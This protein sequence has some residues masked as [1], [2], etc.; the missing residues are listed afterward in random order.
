MDKQGL[1]ID[2]GF[3][4]HRKAQTLLQEAGTEVLNNRISQIPLSVPEW[5]KPVHIDHIYTRTLLEFC[6]INGVNTLEQLLFE[7]KG[8]IFCSIV[9][10]KPCEE[11]YDEGQA[12]I[13]AESIDGFNISV[14]FHLSTSK[15][16]GETLRTHLLSGGEFAIVAQLFSSSDEKVVFQPLI[17]GFP[18]IEDKETGASSWASYSDFYR[19]HLEDFDEFSCVSEAE[20]PAEFNE[21]KQIKESAFKAALGRIL[22]ESTPK[23]WGGEASDFVTSHLHVK[24]KRVS[25]AFLLKGPAKFSPMTVKHLGKNGDQIVRLAHEPVDVLIVQHCHDITPAV[26]ETLKVF[27]TQPSNPRYYCLI[28]GRES[29]RLL[30]A[31]DAKEFAINWPASEND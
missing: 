10:L 7:K 30:N 25:A 2:P 8:S 23:D 14:E 20:M 31:F 12:V 27:A 15:V 9:K 28:D 6:K 16:T 3:V 19:L 13:V 5:Q 18:Y 29:L 1:M 24:G 22:K 11:I 21:M 26:I 17:I 4:N